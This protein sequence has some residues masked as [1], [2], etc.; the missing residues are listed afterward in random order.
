MDYMWFF[1]VCF[2]STHSKWDCN[3]WQFKRSETYEAKAKE[4]KWSFKT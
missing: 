2:N 3:R 4:L 1:V